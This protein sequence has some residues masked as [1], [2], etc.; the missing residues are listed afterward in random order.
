MDF[1]LENSLK[2]ISENMPKGVFQGCL[3]RRDFMVPIKEEHGGIWI[4]IDTQQR[5]PQTFEE[6]KKS[7]TEIYRKFE[8]IEPVNRYAI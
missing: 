4:F 8:E 7:F 6:I 2:I 1:D 5:L 3:R